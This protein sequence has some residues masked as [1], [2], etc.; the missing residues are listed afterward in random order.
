MT[1]TL[2]DIYNMDR[3]QINALKVLRQGQVD[4]LVFETDGTRIWRSRLTEDDGIAYL[5]STEVLNDAGEWVVV[6]EW[7]PRVS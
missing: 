4:D 6:S 3:N 1:L 2:L 7:N 5:V